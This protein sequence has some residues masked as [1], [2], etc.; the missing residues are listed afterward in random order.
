MIQRLLYLLS[1]LLISL[2]CFG[3]DP[4]HGWMSYAVGDISSTGADRITRLEMKWKVNNYPKKRSSAFF[5]P[6]FGMDTRDNKN[7]IQPVSPYFGYSHDAD[8]VYPL[9]G[10][11]AAYTEYY[12]WQPTHN[13]NSEMISAT[14][15]NVLHGSLVYTKNTDSYV[16]V[17]MNLATGDSTQQIVKAQ[18][19]KKYTIPYVVYEKTWPCDE[20]PP[21]E[22]I[23]FHDIVIECDFKDCTKEVRVF[24]L[25][26]PSDCF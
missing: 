2:V 8:T 5:S 9:E 26:F 6:W 18:N 17:I 16:L 4:A 7:L 21:D 22:L 3:Q 14:P 1:L 20:Y 13:K 25:F 11:Y 24:F 23:S 10:A 19:N 12:Q 15:G